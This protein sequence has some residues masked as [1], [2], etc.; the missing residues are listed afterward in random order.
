VP[1]DDDAFHKRLLDLQ[2][3]CETLYAVGLLF[4]GDKQQFVAVFV[5]FFSEQISRQWVAFVYDVDY[6]F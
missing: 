6:S 2:L 4:G 3:L 5:V 1:F